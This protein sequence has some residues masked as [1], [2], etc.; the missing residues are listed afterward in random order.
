[1][2]TTF[3][4]LGQKIFEKIDSTIFSDATAASK[5]VAREIGNI[6]HARNQTAQ[7]TVLGLATG[8]TPLQVYSELIRLHKEEGLSFKRVLSF[9][10]DEYYPIRP[11]ELQ[12]YVRFMNEN[13]F[14]HIDIKKKN[15]HIPDGTLPKEKVY[16]YC[17]LFEQK[18]EEAGGLDVQLLGIGRTGHIGFNEPGSLEKTRTRLVTLDELTRSDAAAAFYGEEHVP[19]QAITMGVGTILKARKIYLMA[20]GKTKANII[21]ETVEGE[22]TEQIPATYLQRHENTKIIL[23][24]AAASELTRRKTPWLVGPCEWDE[25]LIK[26]AVTWLS[27]TTG[28]PIL[29]LTDEDYNQHG[30]SDILFDY[31]R[32]YNVNIH[33]FNVVQHTITGWPGGKPDADDI[34]RPERA[35]PFPKKVLVFSPHPA[36]DVVSMGGTLMRLVDHGHD[37]HVVYQTSGNIAVYD[38]EALRYADFV[39]RYSSQKTEQELYKKV[40]SLMDK[41]QPGDIDS[42]EMLKLKTNI[43]IAEARSSCRYC[44]IPEENV[45]FLEMP[46]YETGRERKN[47]LSEKDLDLVKEVI[48]QIQPHQIYAAGDLSDPHGTHRLCWN[49]IEQVL[50][51]LKDEKWVDDCYV[52]LYRGVWQDLNVSEIDMAVPLSPGE[53]LRKR[54]AIFKHVSQKD[55]PKYPGTISGE[56]W[57][58]ADEKTIRHAKNYDQL[59]LAE[60]DSIEGF[61]KWMV[62]R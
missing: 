3:D 48:S 14:D 33:I 34:N 42:E 17:Q 53:R 21:R 8:S 50:V 30:M 27:L 7:N 26:K 47:K 37:V 29:K 41:K 24:E 10:L 59:G 9:N 28:K 6:I 55:Q 45:H 62:K 16:E 1:M 43:R 32:A 11:Q 2:D 58:V 25:K 23:D 4:H 20:W 56:F 51:D 18:I 22:I 44:G 12:S 60:Y 57:M 40:R 5:T 54:R 46:F 35:K 52:W 13:L 49:A 36:D 38:D 31:G 19:R 61:S 39:S 15:I